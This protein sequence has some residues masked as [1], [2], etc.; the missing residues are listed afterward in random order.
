MRTMPAA[1]CA[2]SSVKRVAI[3]FASRATRLSEHASLTEAMYVEKKHGFCIAVRYGNAEFELRS[4]DAFVVEL[5]VFRKPR[6]TQ[7]PDNVSRE[8]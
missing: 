6:A 7:G 8:A 4:R 2:R 3:G 5:E 1:K